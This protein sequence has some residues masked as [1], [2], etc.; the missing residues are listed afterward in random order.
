MMNSAEEVQA[1]GYGVYHSNSNIR[2]A[3]VQMAMCT[4]LTSLWGYT[5][6]SILS[7]LLTCKL[8]LTMQLAFICQEPSHWS[9]CEEWPHSWSIPRV[10]VPAHHECLSVCRLKAPMTN[11]I[12]IYLHTMFP[13]DLCFMK[14]HTSQIKTKNIYRIVGWRDGLVIKN[15]CSFGSEESHLV[16]IIHISNT[17]NH[18]QKQTGESRLWQASFDWDFVFYFFNPLKSWVTVMVFGK[19]GITSAWK[20]QHS[21]I[22]NSILTIKCSWSLV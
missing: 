8:S 18:Q 12:S 1:L 14:T 21:L 13:R 10:A 16:L 7:P 3:S 9:T 2:Q 17:D 22:I 19:T 4:T 11:M 15:T 5:Y 20:K 6:A